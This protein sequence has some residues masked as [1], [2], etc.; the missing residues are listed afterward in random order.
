MAF[1]CSHISTHTTFIHIEWQMAVY[2]CIYYI[3]AKSILNQ[4]DICNILFSCEFYTDQ[5]LTAFGINVSLIIV[6]FAQEGSV[7]LTG[8][9]VEEKAD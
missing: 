9:A 7:S 5:H 2:Y 1:R 8:Q 6:L 3:S 4:C